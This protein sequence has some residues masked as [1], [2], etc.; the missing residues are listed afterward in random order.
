MMEEDGFRLSVET[1]M[2]AAHV[3]YGG[4][5][6]EHARIEMVLDERARMTLHAWLGRG[7]VDRLIVTRDGLWLASPL[8][9]GKG[10][11]DEGQRTLDEFTAEVRK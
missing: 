6:G 4:R 1:D 10:T 11:L 2:D 9:E 8:S 5:P 7:C 3:A